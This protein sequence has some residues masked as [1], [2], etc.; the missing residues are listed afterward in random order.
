MIGNINR[1]S[2]MVVLVALM[3]AATGCSVF[4][5]TPRVACIRIH[6]LDNKWI[7]HVI[8]IDDPPTSDSG[9][10]LGNKYRLQLDFDW[11]WNTGRRS[12][13]YMEAAT[14]LDE[15]KLTPW[16]LCKYNF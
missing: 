14:D 12:E 9:I 4:I 8:N 5:S 3:V 11:L 10:Q 15:S 16:M 7:E 13:I 2:M 6:D 1:V